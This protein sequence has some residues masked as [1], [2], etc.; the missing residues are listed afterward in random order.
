LELTCLSTIVDMTLRLEETAAD[1]NTGNFDVPNW[2]VL[3]ADVEI[4]PLTDAQLRK[5]AASGKMSPTD[6]V[7][8][9]ASTQRRPASEVKGLFPP[10]LLPPVH[11]ARQPAASGGP[12]VTFGTWYRDH[13]GSWH[14]L[15]QAVAWIFY[16]FLWIPGWWALSL[17]NGG[18]PAD[19]ARG[20]RTLMAVAAGAVV[21]IGGVAAGRI[22]RKGLRRSPRQESSATSASKA[23][24]TL[25]AAE[26]TVDQFRSKILGRDFVPK[27]SF[28][29]T[30]GRPR[31]T[32]TIGDSVFLSYQCL[33][34]MASVECPA[35]P[36]E[37]QDDIAPVSVDQSF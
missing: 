6:M 16:G 29:V 30:F 18:T 24:T 34:G 35:G 32:I 3:L 7:R 12:P 26:L 10:T 19:S 23:P 2:F 28:Y 13:P 1:W 8:T 20:R 11:T 4:G 31:R 36:F 14:I 25:A 17:T 9:D 5:L 21:L 15:V 33:D 37:F 22:D 27:E